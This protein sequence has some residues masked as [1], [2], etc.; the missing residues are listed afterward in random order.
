MLD[1]RIGGS[2]SADGKHQ[3]AWDSTSLDTYCQCPRKYLYSIRRGFRPK[4]GSATLL[5][6]Q[7]AHAAAETYARVRARGGSREDALDAAVQ[8]A[9]ELSWDPNLDELAELGPKDGRKKRTRENLVRSVVWWDDEFGDDTTV[10]TIVLPDGRPA[11]ELSWTFPLDITAPDGSTYLLCGH[12]DRLVRYAGAAYVG[13]K[14]HT[15][16]S[17]SSFY[18]ARY[19]PNTQVSTYTVAGKV[20]MPEIRGVLVEAEQLG[21]GFSRFERDFAH[22]SRQEQD[23]WLRTI[24]KWIKRAEADAEALAAGDPDA[25]PMNQSACSNYGGCTFRNI[26]SKSPVVRERFLEGEFKREFWDPL[27]TRGD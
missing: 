26:C 21:V 23:E 9:L 17:L 22:R 15:T 1:P 12:F 14:K 7:C 2:F 27:R 3:I 5:Y 8:V 19:S 20:Y 6:G 16:N 25:F 24:P 13:E 4:I 11:V 18:F 10:E